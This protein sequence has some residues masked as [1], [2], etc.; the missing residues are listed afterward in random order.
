MPI[1]HSPLFSCWMQFTWRR[2]RFE[3]ADKE[4]SF[5]EAIKKVK[6]DD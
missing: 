3:A 5:D 6:T 2:R 1:L 4:E